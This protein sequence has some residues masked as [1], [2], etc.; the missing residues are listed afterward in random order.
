MGACRRSATPTGI[1]HPSSASAPRGPFVQGPR[2]QSTSLADDV[3][4]PVTLALWVADDASVIPGATRRRAP[5]VTLTW[6]KFR[7]PGSVTFANDEAGGG[8]ARILRRLAKTAFQGKAA[9]TATFSE[10]GEYVLRVVSQRLVR[11]RRPR[12]SVLLVERAG[13]SHGQAAK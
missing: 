9:T 5:P 4:N 1:R 12:I 6:S 3:P 13:E 10:P 8:E 11:R 7:G 2:G